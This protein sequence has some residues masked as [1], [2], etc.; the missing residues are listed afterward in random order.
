M[1][2]FD[3]ED[4]RSYF[5]SR[6]P[7]RISEIVAARAAA[8]DAGWTGEPLS[9][10]HRLVH[11]LTGAGATFGF[12]EISA[13]SRQLETLLREALGGTRPPEDEVEELLS[14]LHDLAGLPRD[15]ASGPP[16]PPPL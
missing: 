4:L 2:A 9:T 3:D 6:L 14:R 15:P 12:A 8:H 10:F 7:A 1:T 13:T 11:S 16:T 5:A